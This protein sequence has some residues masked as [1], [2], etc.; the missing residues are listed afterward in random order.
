MLQRKNKGRVFVLKT[1]TVLF[2]SITHANKFLRIL[3]RLNVEA[4]LVKVGE[5]KSNNGCTYGI[6][7]NTRDYFTVISLLKES[8]L[9]YS[10]K[11]YDIS[12]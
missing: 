10:F 3:K 5:N 12:R 4:K 11:G 2:N 1:D 9:P 8:N 6:A 7:Y